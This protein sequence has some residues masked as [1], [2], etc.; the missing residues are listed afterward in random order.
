[1]PK[2]TIKDQKLHITKKKDRQLTSHLKNPIRKGVNIMS[3]KAILPEGRKRRHF[4]K[5]TEAEFNKIKALMTYDVSLSKIIEITGKGAGTVDKIKKANTFDEYK[6]LTAEHTAK[7]K[8]PTVIAETEVDT[9]LEVEQEQAQEPQEEKTAEVSESMEFHQSF[10]KELI[11]V[12]ENLSRL[13]EAWESRPSQ[14][15]G[16]GGGLFGF[17]KKAK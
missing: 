3:K 6:V 5:M 2:K 15:K 17:G 7:Y 16:G 11:K 12:N 14:E 10:L 8:K 9:A 4:K 13:A 1:M